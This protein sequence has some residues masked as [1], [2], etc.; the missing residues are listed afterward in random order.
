MVQFLRK[1]LSSVFLL[2]NDDFVRIF[3]YIF[4]T[5]LMAAIDSSTSIPPGPLL[6][7][8][9]CS[10]CRRRNVQFLRKPLSS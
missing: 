3:A 2:Y 7:D 10:Y 1:P 8:R 6:T 4:S 5:E 9:L